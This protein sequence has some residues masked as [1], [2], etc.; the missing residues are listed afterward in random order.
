[1]NLPPNLISKLD[2]MCYEMGHNIKRSDVIKSACEWYATAYEANGRKLL[3]KRDM[4]RMMA[5][6]AEKSKPQPP[7]PDS[8]PTPQDHR[9]PSTYTM[10]LGKNCDELLAYLSEHLFPDADPKNRGAY[11]ARFILMQ[12]MIDSDD[13]LV[14][15]IAASE[16]AESEGLDYNDYMDAQVQFAIKKAKR[17]HRPNRRAK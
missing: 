7:P 4:Q 2:A 1:M 12:A 6:V 8:M 17:R 9:P 15:A 14:R 11:I 16:Y 10:S 3:I 13:V 5:A